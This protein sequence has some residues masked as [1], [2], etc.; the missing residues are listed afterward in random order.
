MLNRYNELWNKIDNEDTRPRFARHIIEMA[1]DE[2]EAKV[3]EQ[4]PGFVKETVESLYSG[5]VYLLKNGFS[6]QFMERLIDKVFH[7]F[8]SGPSRFYKMLE[9]CPNFHRIHDEEASKKYIF[10]SVRHSYYWFPWNGD[11]MGVN[12][13]IMK[14]WRIFKFLGGFRLDEYENNTPKDGVVDRFQVARYLPGIG[15]VETHSD[16]FQN[17]RFFI[18]GFMSK[19]G[20]DYE[21]GGFYVVSPGNKLKDIEEFVDVGDISIGYATIL[22]GVDLVDPGRPVDWAKN[23][24]RW[25]FGVYSNSTDAVPNRAIGKPVRISLTRES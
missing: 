13:G 21:K 2:F 14:R 1:Y 9:G 8:Q 10:Q 23:D 5:D 24:G 17:Q 16:P 4:N 3:L 6:K 22:H 25:W 19:R 18:S 11:S 15:R 20:V 7:V 12:Q